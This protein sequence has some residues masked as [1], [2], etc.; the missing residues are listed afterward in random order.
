MN[1][2]VFEVQLVAAVRVHAMDENVARKVVSSVLCSPGTAE[3]R[4]V[5]ENNAALG[6]N[7]PVTNVDFYT[8]NSP[9]LSKTDKR[10][11]KLG[12]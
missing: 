10:K 8:G 2:Y 5:N 7:A 11:S 1:E 12:R 6:L 3:V 9:A 4:M